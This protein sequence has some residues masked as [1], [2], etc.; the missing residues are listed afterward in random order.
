MLKL[1]TKEN[2]VNGKIDITK[3]NIKESLERIIEEKGEEF[4]KNIFIM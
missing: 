4:F 2:D 1:K 3:E